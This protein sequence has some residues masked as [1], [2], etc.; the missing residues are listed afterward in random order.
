VA[1]DCVPGSAA[2]VSV[3]IVCLLNG[4][5][6]R[7]TVTVELEYHQYLTYVPEGYIY[8]V[9]YLVSRSGLAESDWS[10]T[11]KWSTR[12]GKR[13]DGILTREFV[14]KYRQ[15]HSCTLVPNLYCVIL[16]PSSTFQHLRTFDH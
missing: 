3:R 7:A 6:S 5:R 8:L 16:A 11:Q 14:L 2:A 4:F 15:H 10:V 13:P 9:L 1:C 12:K